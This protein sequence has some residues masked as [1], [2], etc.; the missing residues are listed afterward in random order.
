[1]YLGFYAL[2]KYIRSKNTIVQ[3]PLFAMS[4]VQTDDAIKNAVRKA[5]EEQRKQMSLRAMKAHSADCGDTWTCTK[6]S[7]FIPIPD[8][9]VSKPMKVRRKTDNQRKEQELKRIKER[10]ER[11]KLPL[12]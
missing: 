9:I 5:F 11:N 4:Q 10:N 6:E 7:C 12:N 1:M 8:K 3:A 2:Y